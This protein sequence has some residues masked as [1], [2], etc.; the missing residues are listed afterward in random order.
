METQ[1]TLTCQRA[2][3]ILA[4]WINLAVQ[5]FRVDPETSH[6]E[7]WIKPDMQPSELEVA[8]DSVFKNCDD[9]CRTS[10]PVGTTLFLEANLSDELKTIL[11]FT[12]TLENT[13]HYVRWNEPLAV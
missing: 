10:V 5:F 8:R 1:E 4:N 7:H 13:V 12:R 6:V 2:N 9:W 11:T 3:Q